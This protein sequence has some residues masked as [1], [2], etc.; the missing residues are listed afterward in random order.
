MSAPVLNAPHFQAPGQPAGAGQGVGAKAPAGGVLAGFEAM[1]AALFGQVGASA[2]VGQ[3]PVANPLVNGQ[4]V[5]P[6]A[7]KTKDAKD[8]AE[9]KTGKDAKGAAE[10]KA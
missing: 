6:K 9:A 3:T 4:P 2:G 1:L 8:S 5:D 10:T 7:A